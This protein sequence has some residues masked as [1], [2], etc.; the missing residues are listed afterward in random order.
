MKLKKTI[1]FILKIVIIVVI[2]AWIA[3]FVFDYFRATNGTKPTICLKEE[4]IEVENGTYYRCTSFGYK[5]YEYVD[6]DQNTS[7]GFGAAFIKNDLE[8]ELGV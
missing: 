8:K 3:L 4:T 7:Y 1:I 6:I 5:Y 2:V